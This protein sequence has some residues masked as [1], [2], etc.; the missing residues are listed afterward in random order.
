MVLR[1]RLTGPRAETI[2]VEQVVLDAHASW[3]DPGMRPTVL[4]LLPVAMRT[5]GT[6]RIEG[7]IDHGTLAG[8]TEWQEAMVAWHPDTLHRVV[9]RPDE[10]ADAHPITHPTT[11]IT[12]FSGGVDSCATAVTCGPG[13]ARASGPV[14]RA[15]VL[16]HGMDIAVEDAATFERTAN[17]ARQV[18]D[19]LDVALITV[20]SDVRRLE[21]RFAL[22]WQTFTHGIWLVAALACVEHGIGELVIP[23]T[24]PYS[25][26]RLPWASNPITDPMLGSSST[27][28]RHDGAGH[29]KLAK[30]A[31]LV[32]HDS[33]EAALRV[34]WEGEHLDR[35]CGR[36]FKCVSTQAC[37]W[38]LGV[39]RPAA[40]DPAATP[41]DLRRVPWNDPYKQA[42]ARRLLDAAR[43]A[44]REDVAVAL[45][46]VIG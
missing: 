35:N 19:G 30:V 7:S 31:M 28:V 43:T 13:A 22:D 2:V 42:L 33:V 44:G 26:L 3:R 8:L 12:A 23:S 9:L 14:V 15:G 20:R 25:E 4:A 24:Y 5:G 11:A 29:D 17:R 18:L 6:L 27:P 32:G 16:V 46:E 40:F 37:F 21:S 34:C 39:Q 36:C 1:S 38:V 45:E 10:I 41:E